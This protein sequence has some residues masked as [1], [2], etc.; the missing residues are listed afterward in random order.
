MEHIIA[1]LLQDFEH[2]G[3]CDAGDER[4]IDAAECYGRQ[5]QVLEPRPETARYRSRPAPILR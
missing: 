2:G 1:N 4:D 5:H 3:A